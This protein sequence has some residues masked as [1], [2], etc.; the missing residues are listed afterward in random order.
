MQVIV[1]LSKAASISD[2][3]PTRAAVMAVALQT[4]IREFF[5][6]NPLSQLGVILMRNGIAEAVTELSG[7]PVSLR[8]FPDTLKETRISC[9]GQSEKRELRALVKTPD[10]ETGCRRRT[11]TSCGPIWIQLV[12]LLSRMRFRL[13]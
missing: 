3:R 7:S 1:D 12:M 4:F 8:R 11:S 13:L 5:D 10:G 2:M 9:S 6:Q